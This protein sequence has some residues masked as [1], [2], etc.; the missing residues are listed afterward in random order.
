MMWLLDAAIRSTVVTAAG[1]L[2]F[3]CWRRR[4][5]ALRHRVLAATLL[6][7]GSVAPAGLLLPA[8][9]FPMPFS[10]S[11]SSPAPV[12]SVLTSSPAISEGHSA[13]AVTAAPARHR[14]TASGAADRWR[15]G[16]LVVWLAGVLVAGGR[17]IAGLIRLSGIARRA[18][19]ID[20]GPLARTAG[21][22]AAA[23]GLARQVTLL[24][25]RRGELLATWGLR[26]P[27]VLLPWHAGGWSAARV[28]VVLCHE[29]AHV[30]RYDWAIQI[31]SD[32]VSIV[33]WFNPLVWLASRLL[34]RESERAC[35]D[36]VLARGVTPRA[37][38]THL[39]ALARRCRATS[40]ALAIPMARHSTL[41]RRVAA[42]F[43]PALDRRPLS[44][45]ASALVAVALLS[46]TVPA[47][48]LRAGQ[49]GPAPV[50]GVVYD[51]TGA[52]VP[53]VSLKLQDEQKVTYEATTDGA[54]YFAFPTV[55]AGRYVLEAGL[56]GFRP[57]RQELELADAADWHRAIT[58][59]VGDVRETIIVRESR[60]AG[61]PS[62]PPVTPA[63]TR[64]GGN[65]RPPR[66]LVD[67]KPVYPP[68]MREAGREGVVPL[69][70]IISR[71]GSVSSV[72]VLTAQVH[73]DFA[74]AAADA[75]RQWRFDPTLL[76]G[77]PV[78]VVMNVSIEFS[79]SE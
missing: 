54:G 43:N 55:P 76:N 65:V 29:L 22:V 30:R 28:H 6:G 49:S 4:S 36:E 48:A 47:A 2:L 10:I 5:A 32:V 8:L 25:S 60:P 68:A 52:V 56:A 70:A 77:V 53:A 9:T 15:R 33:Y 19:R 31:A 66:K 42:M 34:R 62:A 59:Q 79:L 24:R 45:G 23:Y 20:T 21:H 67:V 63:P 74:I 78:E 69:E 7:A 37:Y 14:E 13:R 72:R 27:R 38:A 64:V 12:A 39:L 16:L 57:L 1:L 3:V 61:A 51:P 46:L 41:E 75:V 44:R 26:R 71:D 58:L 17:L 35:D 73:P 18:E 11:A 40:P 50:E